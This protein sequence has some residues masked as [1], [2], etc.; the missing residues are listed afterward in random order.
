MRAERPAAAGSAGCLC[1]STHEF[2]GVVA[3]VR[4]VAVLHKL[5]EDLCGDPSEIGPEHLYR[6]AYPK[7]S[8]SPAASTK[9][10]R[11]ASPSAPASSIL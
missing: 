3:D 7:S 2:E 9:R 5:G 1:E 11:S 10:T 4:G 8:P 6:A